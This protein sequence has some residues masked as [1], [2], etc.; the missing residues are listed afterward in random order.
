MRT[1]LFFFLAVAGFAG[2]AALLA[3]RAP[4]SPNPNDEVERLLDD[5]HALLRGLENA[6][7]RLGDSQMDPAPP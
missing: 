7:R 6:A 5:C 4:A 1:L 2:L 3:R